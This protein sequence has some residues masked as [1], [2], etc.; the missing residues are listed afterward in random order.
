VK[1]PRP[2]ILAA[3]QRDVLDIGQD[4]TST[5]SLHEEID[6]LGFANNGDFDAAVTPVAYPA[7]EAEFG[8][9]PNHERAEADTLNA[10][11]NGDE[12]CGS[13]HQTNSK[14]I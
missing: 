12:K 3:A 7:I 13:C 4:R 10:S 9:V 6:L 8:R 2:V 14:M 11:G 5:A 1:A